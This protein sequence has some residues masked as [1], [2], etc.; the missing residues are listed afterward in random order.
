[1]RI[2]KN[3]IIII[4]I[5]LFLSLTVEESRA[6]SFEFDPSVQSFSTCTGSIKLFVDVTGED[7]NAADIE[8]SYDPTKIVITDTNS[9][10]PGIQIAEGTAFDSY[11]GNIVDPVQGKILLTA[12]SLPNNLNTLESRELFATIY[13]KYE[14]EDSIDFKIKMDGVGNTLDSNI[15]DT[16][17]GNDLLTSV[18]NG[19]FIL[20]TTNCDNKGSLPKI[21]PYPIITVSPKTITPEVTLKTNTQTKQL[22]ELKTGPLSSV[23]KGLENNFFLPKPDQVDFSFFLIIMCIFFQIPIFI[24]LLMRRKKYKQEIISS[25]KLIKFLI[26]EINIHKLIEKE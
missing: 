9:I 11:W 22:Y 19:T 17:S 15:A 23:E 24:F 20:S 3:L 5:V 8:I 12:G 14:N 18:T 10:D 2:L 13:F 7:S 26:R 4:S 6:A 16:T 21:T 25:N 1:M